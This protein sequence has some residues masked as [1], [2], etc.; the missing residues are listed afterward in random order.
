MV[1]DCGPTGRDHRCRQHLAKTASPRLRPTT[2]VSPTTQLSEPQ[3]DERTHGSRSEENLPGRTA[4]QRGAPAAVR[5][6]QPGDG[7]GG[8]AASSLSTTA[9]VLLKRYPARSSDGGRPA[10]VTA[11]SGA[12]HC[13][14]VSYQQRRG[15]QASLRLGYRWHAKPGARTCKRPGREWGPRGPWPQAA[16]RVARTFQPEPGA[17]TGQ[18]SSSGSRRCAKLLAPNQRATA[19]DLRPPLRAASHEPARDSGGP[20]ATAPRGA[21]RTNKGQRRNSSH[22]PKR[23]AT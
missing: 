12:L 11:P 23:S 20:P 1:C 9:H 22:H 21:T 4:A 2:L 13:V 6:Q 5:C 16:C 18:S 3:R 8:P 19:A 10:S 17:R 7:S 14:H 15:R